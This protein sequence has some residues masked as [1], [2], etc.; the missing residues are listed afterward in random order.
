[1]A[2]TIIAAAFVMGLLIGSFLNVCIARVP[3]DESVVSPRSR[4]THCGAAIA[5]YDNIPLLSYAILRGRCRRCSASIS[6][7]YP[8]VE[9]ATGVW[10]ALCFVPVVHRLG[11]PM[12]P[13][14]RLITHHIGDCVLGCFLITLLV[15]DWQHHRLPNVVTYTGIAAGLFFACAEAVFLSDTDENVI[16][17]RKINL[18]SAG[19]GRSPGNIFLTGAE[20]LIFSRLFATVAAFLLLYLIGAAYKAVR[21]RDGMGLGDAK[22]LALIASFLGFAPTGVGFFLA[23]LFAVLYSIPLLLTRRATTVTALP[24]GTFL[25][26]GGLIA[27]LSGTRLLDS[28]LALFH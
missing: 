25:C 9:F 26:F 4:C 13:L 17:Q 23:L 21:K 2:T 11:L 22:L 20:H 12:D 19:A 1:M 8:A 14:L 28:Y 27:A 7:V 3:L 5:W 6:P 18:N 24:F 16:L 10:F 15:I